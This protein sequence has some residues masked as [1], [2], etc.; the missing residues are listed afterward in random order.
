MDLAHGHPESPTTGLQALANLEMH[1]MRVEGKVRKRAKGFRRLL[2]LLRI[3]GRK[4]LPERIDGLT[5]NMRFFVGWSAQNAQA[6]YDTG[7]EPLE[8]WRMER[9]LEKVCYSF[10]WSR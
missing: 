6:F 1:A 10:L 5:T 9:I 3:M 8:A 7:G 4:G 2:G